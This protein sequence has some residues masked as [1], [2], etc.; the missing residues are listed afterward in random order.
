MGQEDLVL[1][2]GEGISDFHYLPCRCGGAA[3]TI[4]TADD[5]TLGERLPSYAFLQLQRKT[6]QPH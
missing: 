5:P 2:S 6:T 1:P 3:G 4:G